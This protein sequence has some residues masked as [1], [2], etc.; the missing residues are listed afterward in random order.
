MWPKSQ[1]SSLALALAAFAGCSQG[2]YQDF[3]ELSN[4]ALALRVDNGVELNGMKNNGMKNNG[5]KN[6][7]MKNNG[8][9]MHVAS[10]VNGVLSAVSDDL[11]ISFSSSQLNGT[12]V[13]ASL[14]D[15]N[16][17]TYRINKVTYDSSLGTNLYELTYFDG[18]T[19]IPACGTD[20]T[21]AYTK[22]VLNAPIP[23]VAFSDTWNLVDGSNIVS[24]PNLFTFSCVNAAIGKCVVWGYQRWSARQECNGGNCKTQDLAFFHQACTRLVRADYCGDGKYH[25]RNG[26]AIDVSDSLGIQNRDG[27]AGF[28]LEA[29]WRHDG[30]HCIHHTRWNKAD[31]TQ[32][33]AYATDLDYITAVC[34]S[35]LASNDVANC[36]NPSTSK[37]FTAYGYDEPLASRSVRWWAVSCGVRPAGK[38]KVS[39]QVVGV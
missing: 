2:E 22:G 34:P 20:P 37:Y 12:D 24:D 16:T 25:T 9:A 5:M 4:S 35:R 8:I 39:K 23:S 38:G 14:E 28:S 3:G 10:I 6:N 11:A 27:V 15:G 19:W 30:A 32:D 31:A 29:E 7:G 21:G 17:T 1:I 18:F 13:L 36:S 33:T 26:T